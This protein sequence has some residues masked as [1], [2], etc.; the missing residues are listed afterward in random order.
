M[1]EKIRLNLFKLKSKKDL[2]SIYNFFR[3][4]T[5]KWFDNG[6][7]PIDKYFHITNCP[8][9]DNESS[10]EVFKIDG[11]SYHECL[12]C[13]STYTKPHLREGVLDNLLGG[14][15]KEKNTKNIKK[16]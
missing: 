4:K 3:K 13:K 12:S 9:C 16:D 2:E 14:F 1:L 10:K 6:Q 8:L 11:F 15:W 5:S 7:H